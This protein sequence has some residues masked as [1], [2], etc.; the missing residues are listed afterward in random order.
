MYLKYSPFPHPISNTKSP[1]YSS[2]SRKIFTYSITLL[3]KSNP[4]PLYAFYTNSF[5]IYLELYLERRLLAC[6]AMYL[7]SRGLLFFIVY[8]L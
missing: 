3:W 2:F 8:W 4:N 6:Y 1:A 7:V 5:S